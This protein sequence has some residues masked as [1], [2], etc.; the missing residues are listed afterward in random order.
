MRRAYRILLRRYP[1]EHRLQF[2]EEM[3]AVFTRLAEEHRAQGWF[4]YHASS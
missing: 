2:A 4:A 1:R 3:F